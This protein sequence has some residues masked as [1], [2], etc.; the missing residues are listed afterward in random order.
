MVSTQYKF[1][2]YDLREKILNQLIGSKL[3][4]KTLPESLQYNFTTFQTAV[5]LSTLLITRYCL[6]AVCI[7]NIFY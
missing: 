7:V 1:L 5:V 4:L 3:A 6:I 2:V